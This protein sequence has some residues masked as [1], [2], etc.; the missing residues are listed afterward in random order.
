MLNALRSLAFIARHPLNQGRE[1][2]A[3]RRVVAWQIGSR[4]LPGDVAV[5]FVDRTRLLVS[6]GQTGATGNLYC[7]LHE[8]EDMAFV[9]HAL[10]PDDL[11][12]DIGANVGS[13]TVLAA[14]AAGARCLSIEPVPQTFLRLQDNLRLN[15]LDARVDA[16]RI[17]IGRDAGTVKFTTGL[18]TVNH[19]LAE[20]EQSA[21]SADVPV[22]TLDAILAGSV[23]RVV[24]IDVEG[25]E[26]EVL[27]G[28][29][30][31]LASTDLLAVL[32]EL[33]G[34]GKRYGISDS[35]LYAEMRSLGF[36]AARYLPKLRR[37]AWHDAEHDT[38]NT[39]FVREDS[40]LVE[41]LRDA[42]RFD[43]QGRMV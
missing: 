4:L 37:L 34:S 2:A 36:R 14:G 15:D 5:P 33:N 43:V 19:A 1:I 30:R 24:K 3:L 18:D 8:Y 28:A 41:R 16:R 10:R 6:R 40:R 23:P 21:A 13:Y 25:Y 22:A 26:S 17:A 7:G 42:R 12:V 39:L 35:A 32:M 38:G 27:A 9:L 20:G 31:T 11:F 29:G